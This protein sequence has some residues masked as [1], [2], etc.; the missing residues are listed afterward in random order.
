MIFCS[1]MVINLLNPHQ[2]ASIE[3]FQ[4]NKFFLDEYFVGF[5]QY[6]IKLW[7]CNKYNFHK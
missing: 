4:N 7:N 1:F 6:F 3:S 2:F 5:S